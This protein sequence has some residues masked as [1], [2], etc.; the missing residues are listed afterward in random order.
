MNP[1]RPELP[2]PIATAGKGQKQYKPIEVAL[3]TL[4]G[5][6]TRRGKH[7]NTVVMA[8]KPTEEE[9]ARIAR[10]DLIYVHLLTFGEP[11]TPIILNVGSDE[12]ASLYGI[13]PQN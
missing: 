8:F 4:P 1:V 6:P 10:G 13:L 9:A 7:H 2:L 3:A 12:A 11:Q 5:Y